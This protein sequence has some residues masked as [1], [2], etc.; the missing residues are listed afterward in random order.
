VD[1]NFDCSLD[2]KAE[3]QGGCE[4]DCEEPGGALFC[5]GQYIAIQDV[6]ACVAYLIDNLEVSFAAEASLTGSFSAC[7]Y[8]VPSSSPYGVGALLAGLALIVA[9]RR[10]KNYSQTKD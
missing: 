4:I 6:P 5:D 7:S 8:S 1:A 2:C 3:M 9:R 10:R